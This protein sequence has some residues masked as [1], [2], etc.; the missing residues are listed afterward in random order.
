MTLPQESSYSSGDEEAERPESNDQDSQD[1]HVTEDNHMLSSLNPSLPEHQMDAHSMHVGQCVDVLD[2]VNRWTEAEVRK[3]DHQNNRVFI[4]YLYWQPK[5]DEWI[6]DIPGRIAPL[7]TYT[8]SPPGPLRLGQRVSVLD[9]GK[10]WREAFVVEENSERVKVHYRGFAPKFDEY[11]GRDS[12]SR[13]R[14]YGRDKSIRKKKQWNVPSLSCD[15]PLEDKHFLDHHEAHS[16]THRPGS[17]SKRVPSTKGTQQRF[18]SEEEVQRQ[19]QIT[20]LSDRYHHYIDALRRENMEVHPVEGDGNCMFRAVAHQVYGDDRFHSLIREKCMDYMQNQAEFYCQFVVGGM[21]MFPLYIAAKR[22]DGCW[23]DDPEIQAMC[24]MYGRPAHI[25][26]YDPQIGAKR[27]RTFHEAA[28]THGSGSSSLQVLRLSYYGGGHYDSILKKSSVSSVDITGHSAFHYN[29]MNDS[30]SA[31]EFVSS[32]PGEIEDIA[33]HRIILRQHSSSRQQSPSNATTP[34]L[35][36]SSGK[37][38]LDRELALVAEAKRA[39]ERDAAE[40]DLDQAIQ[41]SRNDITHWAE[42][43]IESCLAMSM[44]MAK[45]DQK[46]SAPSRP[47]SKSSSRKTMESTSYDD[48]SSPKEG[49]KRMKTDDYLFDPSAE[50]KSPSSECKGG[51]YD[52]STQEQ[53]A[54]AESLRTH[55]EE[56]IRAASELSDQAIMDQAL[57]ASLEESLTGTAT[58]E[59]TTRCRPDY[60][61][62]DFQTALTL[63]MEP[64]KAVVENDPELQTALE[65]SLGKIDASP[66]SSNVVASPPDRADEYVGYDEDDPELAFALQYSLQDR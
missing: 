4:S 38:V 1:N 60:S 6:D 18:H 52:E 62:D 50:C 10:V 36:G 43:D 34:R 19:R 58:R 53:K 31:D 64:S 37:N 22:Q 41:A 47:S 33:I 56:Q 32:R 48:I 55:E 27:L 57:K 66:P 29:D 63:S 39:S 8:Y 21:Q 46:E 17:S 45:A 14:Q 16:K 11:I 65:M 5:W 2:S 35:E 9:E 13:F 12:V 24:E 44:S 28:V 20:A 26:A 3:I 40:F 42:D 51:R 54:L 15:R 23:G 7:H 25:W 49:P 30:N 59:A 61:D